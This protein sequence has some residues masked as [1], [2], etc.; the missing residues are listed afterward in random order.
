MLK[1]NEKKGGE[2][3]LWNK[4]SLTIRTFANSSYALTFDAKQGVVIKP[5]EDEDANQ[6]EYIKATY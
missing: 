3:F 2:F 1:A 4:E 6:L 5:Y